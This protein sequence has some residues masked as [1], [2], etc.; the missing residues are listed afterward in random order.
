[1]QE[2]FFENLATKIYCTAWEYVTDPVGVVVL[3]HDMGD[4]SKRFGDF[5]DYL[6]A[7]GYLVLAPDL[8]A[9][10]RTAGGFDR[11]GEAEGDCFFDSV[12]DLH[13]LICYALSTYRLPLVMVGVGY[14]ALLTLAYVQQHKDTVLGAALLSPN[15]LNGTQ[16]L[17]GNIVNST[18][19]GFVDNRSPATI[20]NR[21]MYK[22]YEKPFLQDKL[23][24][25]WISRDKNEVRRYVND[26]YCGAQFAFS[27][28]FAQSL[29]RGMMKLSQTKRM[30]AIPADLPI[31]LAA[32]DADPVCEYGLG[33]QKLRSILQKSGKNKCVMRLYTKARHDLLHEINRDEVH[34]DLLDFINRCMGK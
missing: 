17:I 20:Y 5:A 28:G 8:R 3:V 6:N 31:L 32:G 7:N 23:R 16:T 29:C 34:C 9:H 25:A 10:G 30:R 13:Q 15:A 2:F 1:M 22:R 21:Y 18:I 11:R 27:L 19:I 14:G 24:F 26:A 33:T 4:Y 12:S